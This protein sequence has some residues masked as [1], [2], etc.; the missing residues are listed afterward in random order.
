MCHARRAMQLGPRLHIP[1][2]QLTC[3]RH[4]TKYHMPAASKMPIAKID[5]P[6]FGKTW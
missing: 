2:A 5:V 6:R 3:A 1:N 4:S